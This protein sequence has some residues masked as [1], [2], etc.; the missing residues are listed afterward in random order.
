METTQMNKN[1]NSASLLEDVLAVVS[2]TL[3][4]QPGA[5]S[6]EC[7]LIEAGL[8]SITL[9]NLVSTWRAAG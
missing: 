9:M 6:A 4:L 7:N 2:N 5:V 8:D 1:S 3:N